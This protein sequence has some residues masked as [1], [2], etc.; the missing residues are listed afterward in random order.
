MTDDLRGRAAAAREQATRDAERMARMYGHLDRT[1][2]TYADLARVFGY[3]NNNSGG[4]K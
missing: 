4:N 1:E 2:R 3:D